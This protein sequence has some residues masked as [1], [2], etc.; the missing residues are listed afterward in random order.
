MLKKILF[1]LPLVAVLALVSCDGASSSDDSDYAWTYDVTVDNSLDTTIVVTIDTSTLQLASI[2]SQRITLEEGTHK[3][4]VK[5]LSDSI[6]M[7]TTSFTLSGY[8]D[9]LLNV[10]RAEYV[11]NWSYYS[12]SG[13]DDVLDTYS[14]TVD[15][16]TF[17][18]VRA[19]LVGGPDE[20]LISN[21]WDYDLDVEMPEEITV[22]NG[23]GEY[24][25]K[26]YRKDIFVI[27]MQL[28]EL[29]DSMGVDEESGVDYL[30]E[31]LLEE[32]PQ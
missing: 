17:E 26:L 12:V 21:D 9:V 16:S 18:G 27:S 13:N 4:F 23:V 22:G 30:E 20:L 10:T 2:T 31:L 11:K 8:D 25:T 3:V 19:E 7:D 6:V 29:F 1:F 15:S 5:T 24:R 32:D 28:L 14:F